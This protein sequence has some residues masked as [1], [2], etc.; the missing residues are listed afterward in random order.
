MFLRP[1]SDTKVSLSPLRSRFL[2]ALTAS[3][4]FGLPA[5]A[6]GMYVAWQH[7]AGGEIHSAGYVDWGYLLLHGLAYFCLTGG[8]IFVLWLFF[9]QSRSD[10]Q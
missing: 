5:A 7:N 4:L 2:S 9:G 6:L 8:P 1:K 3:V 10:E